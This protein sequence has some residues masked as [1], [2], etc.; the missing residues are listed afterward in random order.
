MS[1]TTLLTLAALAVI[2]AIYFAASVLLLTKQE[3]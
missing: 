1:R 3:P 2:A